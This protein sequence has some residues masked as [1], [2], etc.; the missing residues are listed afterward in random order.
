[1]SDPDVHSDLKASKRFKPMVVR[2][3][4][5]GLAALWSFL[6]TGITMV[7]GLFRLPM[8]SVF[9]E[10]GSRFRL[11]SPDRYPRGSTTILHD[12]N[13][14]VGHDDRGLFVL[15]LVCTHLGCITRREPDGSFTC[16]C[17]GSRFDAAGGVVKG[18]APTP[19]RYFELTQSP[20]GALMVDTSTAVDA[21]T[22]LEPTGGAA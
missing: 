16:P 6:V 17:H 14:L 4:F 11:G 22:R 8:P 2:R 7:V 20:S 21:N 3:D 19:L 1:M 5:L 9:P 18:P 12:R 10:L 15:S 13:I